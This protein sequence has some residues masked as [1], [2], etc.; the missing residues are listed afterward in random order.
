MQ[1]ELSE[2]SLEEF[3]QLFPIVLTE[4]DKRWHIYYKEE[5][6]YLLQL[7]QDVN[8]SRISHIG[9]TAINNIWAKPIIDIIIEARDKDSFGKSSDKLISDGYLCMTKT[10]VRIDLNKGYTKMAFL[11]GFS[12]SYQTLWRQR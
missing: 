6:A 2:M 5:K 9:S 12:Y 10:D 7:L 3:W 11:K 1:K 4:P 8:T